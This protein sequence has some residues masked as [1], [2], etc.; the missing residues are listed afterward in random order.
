MSRAELKRLMKEY[1]PVAAT[2]HTTVFLAT[3]G[4][5]YSLTDYGL[6]VSLLVKDIPIIANNLPSPGAGKLAVAWGL[7]SVTGPV[8]ALMTITLTP[9]VA[10]FWWGRE[11][12][13]KLK[14]ASVGEE[15]KKKKP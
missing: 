3:L 11:V 8:R 2:F 5:F 1:G 13:R 15:E 6:D 4:S 7:T 10:R 14:N 9:R 12:K